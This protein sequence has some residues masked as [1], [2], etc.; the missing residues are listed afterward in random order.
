MVKDEGEMVVDWIWNLCNLA[1]ESGVVPEGW[2][3]AGIV[4]LFK[5]KGER[6]EWDNY[7]GI[8]FL[9]V[10]GKI[11]AGMLLDGQ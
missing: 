11:Y 6:T 5:G 8:S 3:S 1:F 10:V 4:P 2:R 7:R 9:S